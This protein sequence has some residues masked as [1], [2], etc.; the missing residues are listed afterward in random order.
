MPQGEAVE[1]LVRQVADAAGWDQRVA[2]LRQIPE[3]F[4][5]AQH[6]DVYAAIAER[7]YVPALAPDFAHLHWRDDYEL[8]FFETAYDTAVAHTDAFTRVDVDTLTE[9]LHEHPSTVMV[10]RTILG[11]V[12]R[13]LADATRQLPSELGLPPVTESRV[14]GMEQRN[15]QQSR[16][17]CRAL[18]EVIAR[19]MDGRLFPADP[20]S[21]MRRKQH[22]PDTLEGWETVRQLARDGV[23]YALFL[24]QR[25]YGGAFRQLLDATS[26]SRG[27]VIED[28]VEELFQD[29]RIPHLREADTSELEQRFGITVRPAPDFVM[30]DASDRLAAM[31][32]A[33]G[34]ND[35]GTARDKAA[36]FRT[37]RQEGMRLGGVP[38]FAALA[39]LGWR[40]TTDA[41]GPVVE[42]CDGRVFT[43][44]T[45]DEMLTVA[46]LPSLVG[47]ADG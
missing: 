44:A 29:R 4:G 22:K 2:I 19:L 38:V 32:E 13:E 24:H 28:A 12:P 21:P 47:L 8:S 10:L 30:F 39:G 33:K 1:E 36:R 6:R 15:R 5:R 27:D 26:S 43:P 3:K 14:K 7:V 11:Y 34:T 45:L 46:P 9:L 16:S 18:A 25:H 37:L 35:G 41:L 17:R 20:S 40:R 31:L 23:P 42:A